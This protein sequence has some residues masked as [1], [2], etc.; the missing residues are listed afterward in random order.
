[1]LSPDETAML[2][3]WEGSVRRA[4]SEPS[5]GS[6]TTRVAEPP[7]PNRTVPRSSEIA[8][9]EWP[10]AW[11][12]SSSAKTMSSARPVDHQRPVAALPVPA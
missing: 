6:I 11:I 2:S 8:V 1:M 9:K 7:S 10:A 4:F 5:I 3:E 12:A